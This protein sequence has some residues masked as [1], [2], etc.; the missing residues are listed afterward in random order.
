[1]GKIRE[2]TLGLLSTPPKFGCWI[3]AVGN[4]PEVQ[5][6][7]ATTGFYNPDYTKTPL[8]LQ[9]DVAA[10]D[11][12]TP[13]ST[14]NARTLLTNIHWYEVDKDNNAQSDI[15]I[16]GMKS[17]PPGYSQVIKTE[18]DEN[19][20]LLQIGKNATPDKPLSLR[21]TADLIT[22]SDTF[23]I[24]KDFTVQCRDM[25][26]SVKCK[27]DT[28]DIV[29][30]NPIRDADTL[31]IRLSV[32][33]NNRKADASHYHP[34]WEVRR[35]DGSWSRYGLEVTDYWLDIDL[36]NPVSAKLHLDLMGEGVSLRVRLRYDR[37]GD[38]LNVQLANDDLS[39]PYCRLECKRVLGRYDHRLNNVTNTLAE[40]ST[41]IRPTVVFK[42]VKGDIADP[43]KYFV[44]T[45]YAGKA[46]M[47]LTEADVIGTG[48]SID[49]PCS[50]GSAAGLKIGYSVDEI[51]PF[52]AWEDSDGSIITDADGSILL[53]R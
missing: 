10:I 39:V 47:A 32:W 4:V 18:G 22:G 40:W 6:Y 14:A 30:Y 11:G 2:H 3:T 13:L 43:E 41:V 9:V 5:T 26:P 44:V 23:H 27:F 12:D 37:N 53:I 50:K 33:E 36:L 24:V 28:P 52:L 19:A 45:F 20:G 1:M 34:V 25:T 51:G 35:D 46:G 31:P 42:D 7:D 29:P 38:P 49:I 21:F 15:M 17:N 48:T 16:L 8:T